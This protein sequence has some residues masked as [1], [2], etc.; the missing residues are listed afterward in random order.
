[1]L[2]IKNLFVRLIAKIDYNK[3]YADV[4]DAFY[5]H[6]KAAGSLEMSIAHLNPQLTPVAY[7]EGCEAAIA[8]IKKAP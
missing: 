4:M 6:G 2:F 8:E 7:K 5:V 1:M 3:G